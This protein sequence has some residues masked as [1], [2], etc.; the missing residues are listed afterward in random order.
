MSAPPLSAEQFGLPEP[1]PEDHAHWLPHLRDDETLLWAGRA[2]LDHPNKSFRDRVMDGLRIPSTFLLMI[3]VFVFA[4]S[5]GRYGLALLFIGVIVVSDQI[6]HWFAQ[7]AIVQ[8]RYAVSDQRLLASKPMR[9]TRGVMVGSEP[10]THILDWASSRNA[11]CLSRRARANDTGLDRW[12][13][14]RLQAGENLLTG[15]ET[16]APVALVSAITKGRP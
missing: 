16:P 7:R 8:H 5:E 6:G 4:I 9:I 1:T 3:L 13:R 10:L 12:F 14:H 15:S 2:E 11:R